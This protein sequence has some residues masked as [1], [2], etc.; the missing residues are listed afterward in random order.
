M[1]S[2][3]SMKVPRYSGQPLL[4]LKDYVQEGGTPDV[5]AMGVAV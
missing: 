5:T 3:V 2:W 4:R 1:E